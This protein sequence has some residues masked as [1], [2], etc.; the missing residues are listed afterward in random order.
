MST[1]E[2]T[3]AAADDTAER[4]SLYATLLAVAFVVGC[5]LDTLVTNAVV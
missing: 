1:T 3:A 4:S 5:L 2:H